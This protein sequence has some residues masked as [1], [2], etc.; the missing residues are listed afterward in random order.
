MTEHFYSDKHPVTHKDI[1][2]QMID[3]CDPIYV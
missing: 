1:P 3:Y 2:V